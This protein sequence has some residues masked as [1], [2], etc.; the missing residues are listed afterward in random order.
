M[1]LSKEEK[2]YL[3]RRKAFIQAVSAIIEQEVDAEPEI[4]SDFAGELWNALEL[5]EIKFKKKRM[6]AAAL[7]P[8][9]FHRIIN[10]QRIGNN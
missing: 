9:K 1:K 4:I 2:L 3:I 8:S 10:S 5:H 7:A 6:L